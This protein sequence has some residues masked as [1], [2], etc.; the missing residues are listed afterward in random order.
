MLS[1]V[2]PF[3]KRLATVELGRISKEQPSLVQI[4][5]VGKWIIHFCLNCLTNTHA[6]HHDKGAAFV[7]VNEAL[8]HYCNQSSAVEN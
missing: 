7:L 6:I 5:N 1:K 3:S 8:L 4:H 2:T